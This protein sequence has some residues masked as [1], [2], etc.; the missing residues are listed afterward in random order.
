KPL[1][2]IIGKTDFD[3]FPPELA[4]KYQKD[5]QR[6]LETGETFET[7]EEHIPPSGEKLYVNVIKTPICDS[8]G[9]IIG[10]Q[11]IFWDITARR[12]GEESLRRTT[13]ELA[14]NRE[15]LR[16]KNEQMEEDLRM[17]REIQQAIIPQQ[18]PSFP[19]SAEAG[20]SLL[21]FCHRYFP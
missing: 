5:D 21:N 19:K 17:A 13:L 3:F 2:E 18:Y 12:R 11:G 8:Q 6:I 4:A 20:Q 10:L 16:A 15:E 7:V 9:Q 14:R 1:H